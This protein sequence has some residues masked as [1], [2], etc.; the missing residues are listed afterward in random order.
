MDFWKKDR[1]RSSCG[2]KTPAIPCRGQ[3]CVFL[4][5][6][7]SGL[8]GAAKAAQRSASVKGN[9]R[10]L[11]RWV[12]QA[13]CWERITHRDRHTDTRVGNR[14]PPRSPRCPL[15][16]DRVRRGDFC[17]LSE[18][19]RRSGGTDW[20][21]CCRSALTRGGSRQMLGGVSRGQMRQGQTQCGPIDKGCF[22][23]DRATKELRD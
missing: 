5:K 23:P 13:G 11:V 18:A 22:L 7:G 9:T 4:P 10:H 12:R 2:F 6:P 14:R 16:T 19:L 17:S 21:P 8:L 1:P 20:Q 15:G 3:L